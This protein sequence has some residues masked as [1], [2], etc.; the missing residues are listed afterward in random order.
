MDPMTIAALIQAGIGLAGGIQKGVTGYQQ[1]RKAKAYQNSARPTMTNPPAL[2]AALNSAAAGLNPPV[3]SQLLQEIGNTEANNYDNAARIGTSSADRI[4]AAVGSNVNA[5]RMKRQFMADAQARGDNRLA[6]YQA[7]LGTVAGQQNENWKW[8]KAE[9]Y[10]NAQETAAALNKSGTENSLGAMGDIIAGGSAAAGSLMQGK[11]MDTQTALT[12]DM[13]AAMIGGKEKKTAGT[14]AT[15]V[16]ELSSKAN[17]MSQN[18]T[19]N[20]LTKGLTELVLPK[21]INNANIPA[22]ERIAADPVAPVI[23]TTTDGKILENGKPMD[24]R[25][26]ERL[27]DNEDVF[28]DAS[29]KI[30][31]KTTDK[32][33]KEQMIEQGKR[34]LSKNRMANKSF[35]ELLVSSP[36]LLTALIQNK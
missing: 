15:Q 12:K 31:Y 7:L 25:E 23:A 17:K 24:Y 29:G 19:D 21:I 4:A 8:N 3:N 13:I 32:Y 1:K 35:L 5:M 10:L 2:D 18:P 11:Q 26:A 20:T 33:A 14:I 36:E 9:P 27:I 16:G 34:R 6:T 22:A 28:N 30:P